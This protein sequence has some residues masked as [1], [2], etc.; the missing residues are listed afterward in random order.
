M[1]PAKFEYRRPT[2]LEE[3]LQLAA[4]RGQEAAV[5]AGGQSLA[6]LLNRRLVRPKLLIDIKQL[7]L[8]TRIAVERDC[9]L[10][11]ASAIAAPSVGAS[12]TPIRLRSSPSA[13]SA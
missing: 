2:T 9:L 3:T 11:G 12:R 5:L 8:L 6:P 10:I 13:S 1:K 7:S 4:E